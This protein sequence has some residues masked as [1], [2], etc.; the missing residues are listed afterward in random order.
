MA[1]L[2]SE[3]WASI[4][5]QIT[6]CFVYAALRMRS[7]GVAWLKFAS[8]IAH[9]RESHFTSTNDFC[10]KRSFVPFFGPLASLL[11]GEQ[12]SRPLGRPCYDFFRPRHDPARQHLNPLLS[13]CA[14]YPWSLA[15]SWYRLRFLM[16]NLPENTSAL[17]PRR[18]CRDSTAG[19]V[20]KP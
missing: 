10:L 6:S 15:L 11:G 20:P 16:S 9:T 14:T 12:F 3:D 13:Y 1:L 19:I 18:S 8:M 2:A 5:H 7:W 4:D 17:G